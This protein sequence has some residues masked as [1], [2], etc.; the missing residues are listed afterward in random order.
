MFSPFFKKLIQSVVEV[1]HDL[2]T[3]VSVAESIGLELNHQKYELV[4]NDTCSVGEMLCAIHG[5]HVVNPEVATLLGSLIGGLVGVEAA[6][7]SKSRSLKLI[8][9]R[10]KCLHA[11]NAL[12]LL[13]HAFTIPK[14]LYTL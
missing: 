13:C 12:C 5:L 1:L 6:I 8:G 4:R 7:A 2:R 11:H 9:D 10:L 3:V 14:L